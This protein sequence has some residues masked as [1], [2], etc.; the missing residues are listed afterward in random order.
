M[1]LHS[2][3]CEAAFE[4]RCFIHGGGILPPSGDLVPVVFIHSLRLLRPQITFMDVCGHIH[5]V[6]FSGKWYIE[7]FDE[8]WVGGSTM[9]NDLVIIL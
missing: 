4:W 9:K 2:S 1:V 5:A 6:S 3:S 8:V 7:S